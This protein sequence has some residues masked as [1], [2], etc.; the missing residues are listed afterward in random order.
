MNFKNIIIEEYKSIYFDDI[1]FLL[2]E[3]SA[4]IPDDITRSRSIKSYI[5][6]KNSYSVVA[7]ENKKIIAFGSIFMFIRVRGGKVGIL[8]DIIVHKK[9]RSKKIGSLIVKELIDYAEENGCFKISL[10]TSRENCK[11]YEK[12]NFKQNGTSMSLILGN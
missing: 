11:F 6:D 7:K 8:E 5:N 9:F 10:E 3:I 2:Q 4:F 1:C 12:L